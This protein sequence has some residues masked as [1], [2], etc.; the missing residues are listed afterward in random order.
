VFCHSNYQI[1]TRVSWYLVSFDAGAAVFAITENML[2]SSS[3]LAVCWLA[4]S[5]SFC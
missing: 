1:T 3:F 2:F 5:L 4:F